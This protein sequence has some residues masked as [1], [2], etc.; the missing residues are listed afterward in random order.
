[1]EVRHDVEARDDG[2][3]EEEEEGRTGPLWLDCDRWMYHLSHHLRKCRKQYEYIKCL[4]T[5]EE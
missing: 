3:Q 4:N 5:G 2:Q 1:M